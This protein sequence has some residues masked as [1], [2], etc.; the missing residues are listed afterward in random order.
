MLTAKKNKFLTPEFTIYEDDK[1]VST[2]ELKLFHKD[3]FID[4]TYHE[5]PYRIRKITPV[6]KELHIESNGEI[7]SY[8]ARPYISGETI[9]IQIGEIWYTLK[10]KS[11][12][13]TVFVVLE[14]DTQI[15]VIK[16]ISFRNNKI[17]IDLPKQIPEP[18]QIF[19]FFVFWAVTGQTVN[20]VLHAFYQ[21]LGYLVVGAVAY[22]LHISGGLD[23]IGD[24]LEK[25]NIPS[26]LVPAIAIFIGI[27][28]IVKVLYKHHDKAH[29]AAF[30]G[31]ITS[32]IILI[33][34]ILVC[35]K[36]P[37]GLLLWIFGLPFLLYMFV[38]GVGRN[39]RGGN[40]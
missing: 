37:V 1:I 33:I 31:A 34:S 13:S 2:M 7:L 21:M 11:S 22:I 10:R 14:G 19:I 28:M 30:I 5:R 9:S 20:H 15:G 40:K 17:Q 26:A 8:A 18:L 39:N 25:A 12:M 38:R 27:T 36:I 4:F 16:S 32:S 29:R 35:E 23:Y 3:T 6:L 24:L